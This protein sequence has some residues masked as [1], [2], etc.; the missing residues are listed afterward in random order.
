MKVGTIKYK[1]STN[2]WAHYG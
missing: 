1:P 2:D